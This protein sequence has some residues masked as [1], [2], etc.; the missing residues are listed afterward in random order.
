MEESV[1]KEY[2][3]EIYTLHPETKETGWDIMFVS[4]FAT[5]K[6][7]AKQNL[8]SFPNFD[9]IILYNY[10][11]DL[12]QTELDLYNDGVKFLVRKS[13]MDNEII[14]TYKS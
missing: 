4:T 1:T 13:Y 7:E 5:S 8:K 12:S 11:S 14:N 10:G 6:E 3:F 9:T 2:N